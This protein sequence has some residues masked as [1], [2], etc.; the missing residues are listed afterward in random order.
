MT[1]SFLTG[2]TR[3]PFRLAAQQLLL[4]GI[5][6]CTLGDSARSSIPPV[7]QAGD[8]GRVRW[9]VSDQ[10]THWVPD[11]VAIGDNGAA[12]F[13]GLTVNSPSLRLYPG[14]SSVPVFVTLPNIGIKTLQTQVAI[15]DSAPVAVSLTT[16]KTSASAQNPDIVAVVR[17]YDLA[18]GGLPRWEH[19]L[20]ESDINT[21]LGLAVS[22]DG[23]VIL[24][25]WSVED[26]GGML[27]TAWDADGRFLSRSVI[28]RPDGALWPNDAELS[29]DGSVAMFS[30]PLIGEAVIYDVRSGSVKASIPDTGTFAGH[31]LS[32]D[33]RRFAGVQWQ[34]QV[35]HRLRVFE[36]DDQNQPV[37]I[38]ERIYPDSTRLPQVALDLS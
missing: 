6:L 35:G 34:F 22:D 12:V 32:G 27:V 14:G 20:P 24:T 2:H 16:H 30:L 10:D 1:R 18:G 38:F 33:G 17:A 7:Q 5:V 37:E 8:S 19:V 29:R 23:A 31:A 15:A 36:L 25:W 13:A 28:P 11:D 26:L 4:T 3:S 21:D 9:R